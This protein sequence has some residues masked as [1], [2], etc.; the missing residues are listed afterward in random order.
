MLVYIPYMDPMG[1]KITISGVSGYPLLLDNSS[2]SA[3][4]FWRRLRASRD[5]PKSLGATRS[6][7][8]GP[9][10]YDQGRQGRSA[11]WE[12]ARTIIP[13]IYQ[14]FL[15]FLVFFLRIICVHSTTILVRRC[16]MMFD[17]RLGGSAIYKR[18][19]KYGMSMFDHSGLLEFLLLL[20][21]TA[22]SS[23]GLVEKHLN[24]K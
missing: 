9:R 1:I 7:N 3:F 17:D 10:T 6:S 21:V 22:Q 14:W 5:L 11:D 12:V 4:R 8:R 16:F 19:V 23:V 18:P 2:I 15:R 24:K 13:M 20:Q